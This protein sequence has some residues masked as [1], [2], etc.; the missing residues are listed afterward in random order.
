MRPL[1]VQ[2]RPSDQM[3]CDGDGIGNDCDPDFLDSCAGAVALRPMARLDSNDDAE[4]V[5]GEPA[6]AA[7]ADQASCQSDGAHA[8][9]WVPSAGGFC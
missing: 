3:D 6:C 1:P 7:H 5:F 4:I 2:F 9:R 8:C